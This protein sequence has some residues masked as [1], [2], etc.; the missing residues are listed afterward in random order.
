MERYWEG[1]SGPA[2]Q[3][4]CGLGRHCHHI[5]RALCFVLPHLELIRH[6]GCRLAAPVLAIVPPAV[7]ERLG[8]FLRGDP[9]V[10]S[11]FGGA[12]TSR[13]RRAVETYDL[14]ILGLLGHRM[15]LLDRVARTFHLWR[16]F[17][18]AY[19]SR[20]QVDRKYQSTGNQSTF[21]DIALHRTLIARNTHRRQVLS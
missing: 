20:D 8:Q 3:H 7:I 9:L 18:R 5:L 6:D 21:A 4:C 12:T 13:T 1:Y 10:L 19:R 15:Y 14:R 16:L 2:L 17:I 11:Y